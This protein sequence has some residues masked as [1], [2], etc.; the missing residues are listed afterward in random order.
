MGKYDMK[1][2]AR[3][4]SDLEREYK[5]SPK[6]TLEP[7]V[8]RS[9]SAVATFYL[10]HGGKTFVIAIISALFVATQL[11][12]SLADGFVAYLVQW[13]KANLERS[14]NAT[15][16]SNINARSEGAAV[17]ESSLLLAGAS[18]LI[19][20]LLLGII[21]THVFQ[22]NSLRTSARIHSK[23]LNGI[24][25]TPLRFFDTNPSGRILN[26]FSKDLLA[27]DVQLPKLMLD[28]LQMLLIIVGALLVIVIVNPLF[29]VP[30]VLLILLFRSVRRIYLKTSK[31]LKR[32]DGISRFRRQTIFN[33]LD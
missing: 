20:I 10:N 3:A 30:L 5:E 33:L 17:G 21:R 13:E 22:C 18:L 11:V 1:P 7:I 8:E 24:L 19:A 6:M 32:L 15:L 2:V 26:K 4:E 29:I 12:C 16:S 14:R 25:Q 23:M 9:A 28:A 27:M 31:P